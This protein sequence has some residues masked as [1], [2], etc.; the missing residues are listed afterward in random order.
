MNQKTFCL[1][2]WDNDFG[3]HCTSQEIYWGRLF[4]MKEE[5]KENILIKI[6]G[7]TTVD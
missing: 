3:A 7:G 5:G 1:Y 4:L 6:E 2:S